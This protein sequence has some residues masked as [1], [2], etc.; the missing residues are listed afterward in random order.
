[1]T[2]T[3]IG[4]T[5]DLPGLGTISFDPP[6]TCASCDAAPEI[7]LAVQCPPPA[8]IRTIDTCFTHI[9]EAIQEGLRDLQYHKRRRDAV[10]A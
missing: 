8:D 4:G 1:M 10:P 3:R 9:G 2:T 6:R 5:L 7:V